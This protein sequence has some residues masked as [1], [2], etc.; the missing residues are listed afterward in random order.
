MTTFSYGS[1][2]HAANEVRITDYSWKPYYG[3]N[4]LRLVGRTVT[5]QLEGELQANPAASDPHDDIITK[6]KA[7]DAAYQSDHG[8]ILFVGNSA[9]TII[10]IPDSSTLNGTR[11]VAFSLPDKTGADFAVCKTYK[12]VLQ[13]D[14]PLAAS[15]DPTWQIS[16]F[17]EQVTKVGANDRHVVPIF[18]LRGFVVYHERFTAA[19]VRVLQRGYAVGYQAMPRLVPAPLWP[20]YELRKRRIISKTSPRNLSL[21]TATD[22]RIDWR[23][24]FMLPQDIQVVVTAD[25]PYLSGIQV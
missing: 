19:P 12:I 5:I 22:Y 23:Y 25:Y 16:E 8:D 18:S 21:P 1:Y 20:D 3:G 24:E 4:R 6:T 13:A 9:Q 15:S 14:V 10:S 11:V 2:T 7:L 17:H